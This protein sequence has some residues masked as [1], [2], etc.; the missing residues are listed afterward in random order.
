MRDSH[1]MKFADPLVCNKCELFAM[2]L[3]SLFFFAL[4]SLSAIALASTLEIRNESIS[5]ILNIKVD[6]LKKNASPIFL[7]LDLLPGA[8]D[9]IENPNSI[10][11]LRVDTGMQFWL[12]ESVDLPHAQRLTFCKDYPGCLAILNEK[13]ESVYESCGIKNLIPGTGERP[14]CELSVF[15][16]LMPMKEVCALLDPDVPR[17]DN[18]SC[19]TGLGFAG[20]VWAARLAPFQNGPI[21]EDS[22]LEHMELRKNL[23]KTDIQDVL[24]TLY[25]QGYVPWQ[26]EMP[27][28]EMDFADMRSMDEKARKELLAQAIDKFL[29]NQQNRAPAPQINNA[30]DEEAEA[31]IML[32]PANTIA[33]LANADNPPE[34]VQLFTMILKPLSSTLLLDVT[35]YQGSPAQ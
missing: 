5:E 21:T 34:D 14:V 29:E 30:A 16:P 22:L 26:A 18:G 2:G 8:F 28:M 10:A 12:Y 33:A 24:N 32:A 20:K 27:G 13:G 15:R 17:D 11:N 7:R 23:S 25:S 6:P 19:L 35:A 1:L 31:S 4:S 3:L 9:K